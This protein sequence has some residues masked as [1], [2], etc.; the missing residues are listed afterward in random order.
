MAVAKAVVP[1]TTLQISKIRSLDGY[2]NA[3][4]TKSLSPEPMQQRLRVNLEIP[5][6]AK[7]R[8][9]PS[10]CNK[11]CRQKSRDLA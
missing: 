3:L 6:R 2:T 10:L 9:T 11:T 5:S 4:Q 8:K 7:S 1:N